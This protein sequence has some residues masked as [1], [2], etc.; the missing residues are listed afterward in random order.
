M[1]PAAL[2]FGALFALCAGACT[3][4]GATSS[5]PAPTAS[6]APA[7]AEPAP[8]ESAA[9]AASAPPPVATGPWRDAVAAL[10][11]KDAAELL[12]ALP[13]ADR[14]RP[15]IRLVRAR[16]AAMLKDPRTVVA[17][18]D[19]LDLPLAADEAAAW[20]AEAA[21]EV[22]PYEP[23]AAYY[24]AKPGSRS[25]LRAG[26]AWERAGKL[27]EAR[28]AYDRAVSQAKGPAAEAAARGARAR[29]L[30]AQ[31][32]RSAA[33]T[34]A[35][36]VF[37]QAPETAAGREIAP[38]LARLDPSWKA[39]GPEQLARA[40]KLAAAGLGAEAIAAL[41]AAPSAPS[42]P[43]EADLLHARGMA[44]YKL[45]RYPEATEALE[46]SAKKSGSLDDTF[47]AA[48]ALSRAN[49]D[50][51]A[52]KAYRAFVKEHPRHALSDEASFLVARLLM[53]LGRADEAAA[54]YGSYLRKKTGGKHHDAAVYELG[55]VQM[56]QKQFGKARATFGTL[57]RHEEQRPEAARLRELEGVA[58]LRAG[59]EAGAR[60]IF[61]QVIRSQPLS[62]A[63]QTARS[64][65]EQMKASLPPL[66]DPADP[67]VPP[68]LEV[69]LPTEVAFFHRLGLDE[70]AEDRL[71]PQE[72]AFSAGHGAR[73]TEALCQAYG[74]L[75]LATRR[76]RVGQDQVK[77]EQVQREAGAT[78]RWAWE[79]LYPAPYRDAVQEAERREGLPTGL[80]HAVMRQESSFDPD[81]VSPA[82]AVGLMQLLP[83]TARELAQRTGAPYEEGSLTRPDRNIDLGARYLS[84]LLKQWKGNVPLA[85]AS[86]NAGPRAVSRW[87]EH[88]GSTEIDLW[89]ARIPYAETRTYVARVLGNLARDAYLAGT[90]PAPLPLGVDTSLRAE[91]DA[92]LGLIRPPMGPRNPGQKLQKVRLTGG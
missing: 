10:R 76:Y 21:L 87:L 14:H 86:Y 53:L 22:G 28:R 4:P 47:H 30:E 59:D 49:R 79:C 66:L 39:S 31:G 67:A 57:A 56:M 12:D 9:P 64:R 60:D 81:V 72:R 65:L 75:D 70:Q 51:E 46:K 8:E 84:M 91:G 63:A 37:L 54:A 25:Q 61:Q 89:V 44:L 29:L 27:E 2:A 52:I 88:A 77:I 34:D 62:W 80:I 92:F 48:R 50:E 68:P 15:E 6:T 78:N 42:A 35:R 5:T 1:R 40:E 36:W 18:L 38:L 11:W 13:E 16:V 26:Q 43:A 55:L 17:Q 73:S 85:V 24:T 82:L 45:R 20:R 33:F 3:R 7:E 58:A 23:A 71:R 19:G 90:T 32:Q 69:K 83:A 74:Q 41:D